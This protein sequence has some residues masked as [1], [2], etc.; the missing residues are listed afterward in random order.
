MTSATTSIDEEESSKTSRIHVIRSTPNRAD[1]EE[2][3][4][5][6]EFLS[7]QEQQKRCFGRILDGENTPQNI[8]LYGFLLGI[9][10]GGGLVFGIKV[11][12]ALP[13]LGYFLCALALFHFLEYL[14]TALYNP[15]KLTLDSYLINHSAHYHAAHAVS[16]L[17]FSIECYLFPSWRKFGWINVVGLCLVI[18]GQLAR[19]TAM[20]SAKS[21]F[22]HR[23]VDYK[24][25]DH[26][27]VQHGIYSLMRHPSYF[28]FYWWAV[29]VQ[30]LLF[31]PICLMLFVFYLHRFFSER[32]SY[33]EYTLLRFFGDEWT[34]YKTR[35]P[36]WMPFI[37]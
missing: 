37:E 2:L 12:T 16:F 22:S 15:R 11:P 30:C 20:M 35:T 1:I 27:L 29:G 32:I 9:V 3:T 8:S 13:Q 19:T 4:A 17:E 23:I 21:N 14:A 6:H 28:G 10:C 5:Y 34:S 25:P 7:Y 36:T 31:N 33:E 24:A 18:L 26:Q